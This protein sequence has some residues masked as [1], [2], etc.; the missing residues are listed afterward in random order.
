MLTCKRHSPLVILAAQPVGG[1]WV[2]ADHGS[3]RAMAP[4]ATPEGNPGTEPAH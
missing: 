1:P 3:R 4:L 2:G